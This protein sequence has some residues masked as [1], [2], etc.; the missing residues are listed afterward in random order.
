MASK[1]LRESWCA[2]CSAWPWPC[3][4]RLGPGMSVLMTCWALLCDS[5]CR[6]NVNVM[7]RT[8]GDPEQAPTV[9]TAASA[10]AAFQ[11]TV[12]VRLRMSIA[13]PADGIGVMRLPGFG[14]ENRGC[15]RT[16]PA[17]S[18]KWWNSVERDRRGDPHGDRPECRRRN[19]RTHVVRVD[20]P[21][22]L[23]LRARRGRGPRRTEV[24]HRN[25]P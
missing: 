23:A 25:Q 12:R 4:D 15:G 13:C 7:L 20:R 9:T 5:A 14:A 2:S 18:D 22:H 8:C 6:M 10:A 3:S 17:A 19:H 1:L 11:M 16:S 21:R 24:H